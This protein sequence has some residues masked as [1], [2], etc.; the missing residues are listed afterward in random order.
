[1]PGAAGLRRTG[2]TRLTARVGR[3]PLLTAALAVAAAL[4]AAAIVPLPERTSPFTV[5]W[6]LL[7][8]LFCV[9]EICVVHVQFRREAQS[10]SLS[11]VPLVIGL[12]FDRPLTVVLAYLLGAAVALTLHRRQSWLK[13]AFNLSNFTVGAAVA[14]ALFA[15]LSPH[16]NPTSIEACLAALAAVAV[17][18]SIQTATFVVAIFLSEGSVDRSGMAANF[19]LAM[20]GTMINACLAL[21]VVNLMWFHPQVVWLMV[22]PVAGVALSYRAYVSERENRQQVAFLYESSRQLHHGGDLDQALLEVLKGSR[23][24]FRVEMAEVIIFP[25]RDGDVIVRTGVN[26][27]GS[28]PM[29]P[30]DL[31]PNNQ[32]LIAR[33]VSAAPA[34]LDPDSTDPDRLHFLT[35]QGIRDGMVAVLR[36]ETRPIGLMVVGNRLGEVSTFDGED[37]RLFEMLAAHTGSTLENG[38]LEHSLRQLRDLQHQLRHQALHDPL[39]GMANRALFQTK[40]RDALAEG[41]ERVGVLFI[42]L[43]DFKTVNDS[44]GHVVGDELLR[45]VAGRVADCIRPGDLAARL[46]GDEFAVLVRGAADSRA[47]IAVASRIVDRLRE[48]FHVMGAEVMVR[49]SIGIATREAGELGAEGI[50]RDADEAMYTAKGLGKGRWEVFAPSMHAAV[51]SRH[52]FKADLHRALERDELLVQYQ[53]IFEVPSGEVVAAEALLRWRHPRY[54]LVQPDDFIPLA[55]ETGLIAPIGLWVLER[56]CVEARRWPEHGSGR[57]IAVAVNVSAKQLQR[58]TFIEEIQQVLARTGLK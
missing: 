32:R 3:V 16:G 24:T 56:A 1:M 58:G 45:A 7:A 36:G 43:D 52:E 29:R 23:E 38:R 5:P 15:W 6:W 22:V 55:E 21:I 4:A 31:D 11:E 27:H 34:I 44:L 25:T 53:P 20:L 12:F 54:G 51:L 46:G 49:A 37:L 26:G 40:V 9:A 8:G 42:D 39:T 19:G 57:D 33:M 18:G 13:L 30:V 35:M 2:L 50:L 47:A 14:V 41:R 10:F 17:A 48:P 28:E